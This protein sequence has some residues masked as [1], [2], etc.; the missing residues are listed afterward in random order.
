M[1]KHSTA[2]P[3]KQKPTKPYPS[4]P[5][6]PHA[7]GKW[8]KKIKGQLYYFG[9]WDDPAKAN[10]D[11]EIRKAGI[12][13]GKE[14]RRRVGSP[15]VKLLCNSFLTA[16]Q[17]RVDSGEL[18]IRSFKRYHATCALVIKHFG[19]EKFLGDIGPTD[20]EHFRA[21]LPKSWSVVTLRNELR[22]AKVL[23][24][25]A[26]DADLISVPF[27][28]GKNFTVSEKSVRIDRA[29]RGPKL[30]EASE[31]N[32]LIGL[33]SPQIK[34]MILLSCNGGIG[35]TDLATISKKNIDL[36]R[37][38]V[39]FPRPKTGIPRRFP[40]W[41][42]T[43]TAIRAAV[44]SRPKPC[45]KEYADRVF[46]TRVGNVWVNGETT[47]NAIS[48]EFK[49]LCTEAKIKRHGSFYTLRHVFQTVAEGSRDLAA[50]MSIMGHAPSTN[51][52][53]AVYREKISDE[54]LQAVVDHVHDWLFSE[55]K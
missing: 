15:T 13:A 2:K 1:P 12:L 17:N 10:Q 33:A 55:K 50:V 25:Y 16:K 54:R 30:L 19:K 34:A 46:L 24:H 53:N 9:S 14:A 3:K 35:N 26:Y 7:N 52:M 28:F 29:K 48:K 49:K 44:K 6:F 51:D 45:D 27:K 39:V 8:A 31:I 47:D 43:I 18:A 41:P 11:Y 20:F 38:W 32:R 23:F 22:H 37:G 4:F 21:S 5:L 40:L 42:E 36:K